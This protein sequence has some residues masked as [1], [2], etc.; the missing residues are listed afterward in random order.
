MVLPSLRQERSSSGLHFTSTGPGHLQGF[1]GQLSASM[2]HAPHLFNIEN[3]VLRARSEFNGFAG[4]DCELFCS[5]GVI[6]IPNH[7]SQISNK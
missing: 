6:E 5:T 1:L 2:E 7:K 4:K 3:L